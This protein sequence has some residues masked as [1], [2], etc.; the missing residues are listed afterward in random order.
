MT[1][2]TQ[3]NQ[4]TRCIASCLATLQMMY[5]QL[6][7]LCLCCMCSTALASIVITLQHI[8]TNIVFVVHFA[9]LII[10][11]HRQRFAFEHC[12]QTLSIELCRF[13]SNKQNRHNLTHMLDNGNMLLNFNLYGWSQPT[14]VFTMYA[15]I[16]SRCTVTSLSITPCT[17]KFSTCRK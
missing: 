8:L 15:I 10:S 7:L 11:P 16:K 3:S 12:F 14:L 2:W 5:M 13:H 9:E 17:T 4:I 6:N 1:G